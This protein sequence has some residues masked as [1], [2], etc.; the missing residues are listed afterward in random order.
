MNN[1]LIIFGGT[2]DLSYRK[3]YPALYNLHSLGRLDDDFKIVGIG[4]RNYTNDEYIDIIKGWT[5]EFARTSYSD[6]T[7]DE[8]SKRIHYYKMNFAEMSEYEGLDKKIRELGLKDIMYYYAVAPEWFISITN[9]LATIREDVTEK[10]ARVIIEKPFGKDLESANRLNAFLEAELG[11]E[12]IYH[13]D[14][15]LGKEM[16][17]NITN[18]RFS[19]MVF[20]GI[21]NKDFIESVEINAYERVGVETRAGYYDKSGALKDMVQNHLFQLLSIV[22]MEEPCMECEVSKDEQLEV[23]KSLREPSAENVAYNMVLAQYK[24]YR[25]ENGV[26]KNSKTETYAM[27]RLFIENERWQGVPFII[28]TGKKLKERMTEVIITFKQ[29]LN[30]PRNVLRIKIQ[31]DEGI[32]FTFNIK[33]PGTEENIETVSMDF[34]QSCII[35]NRINTP[36]AYERL[37]AACMAEDRTMFSYWNQIEASWSYVNRLK[38]MY[39]SQGLEVKEY[40]VDSLGPEDAK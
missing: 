23:F 16:I 30:H 29:V 21:W 37:L 24:G 22:A 35:E 39:Y 15:Y 9:G 34:C 5:E 7:F 4:R 19:N 11:A 28:R 27:M 33:K 8:F 32:G 40:E 18:I 13:I 10:S 38:E 36:E 25:D 17:R 12:N 3:L 20:K 31:P 1:S 14:H 2:G 26:D 6:E